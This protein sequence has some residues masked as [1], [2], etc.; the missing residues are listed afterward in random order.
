MDKI[1]I[2]EDDP[3]IREELALLLENEGY[4][5]TA[6]TDFSD[7]PR[8]VL[9]AAPGLILLDLGLPGRD[10]M[11]LCLDI[12]K[13]SRTPI[14][15]VTSRDSASDELRALSL[16]GDDYIT[17]PYNIPVLLARIRAVLRR[18]GG[19][20]ESDTLEAEGLTLHLTRGTVSAGGGSAELTRNELKILAYLM[21][22]AGQ[23]VSRADLIDALWDSQ[24]YIDDNTLSVNMT[25]LRAKLEE[26]GLP[27]FIKTRRGMG[28]QL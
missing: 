15:F 26:I 24:I 19:P 27:G 5:A 10:G 1:I 9:A 4:Q 17:K 25:R 14:I 7:V 20:A 2:I 13:V 18:A 22:H 3:A 16:G 8:Q 12:R 21:A 28:Y 23:I 6:V 11:S